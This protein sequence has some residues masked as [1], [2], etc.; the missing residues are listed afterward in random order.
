MSACWSSGNASF[1]SSAALNFSP[2]CVCALILKVVGIVWGWEVLL[3]FWI[4]KPHLQ[5]LIVKFCSCRK[6]H[7]FLLFLIS[8]TKHRGSGKLVCLLAVQA[9]IIERAEYLVLWEHVPKQPALCLTNGS[10]VECFVLG[11]EY[12]TVWIFVWV[13]WIIWGSLNLNAIN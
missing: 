6:L 4:A 10:M 8:L 12:R 3:N 2:F 13:Q 11:L 7:E 9:L 1:Y 5:E